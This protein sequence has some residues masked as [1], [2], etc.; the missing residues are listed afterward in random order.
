M[1]TKICFVC[2]EQITP[3]KPGVKS[4]G[5]RYHTNTQ[6]PD[7]FGECHG[8]TMNCM[9]WTQFHREIERRTQEALAADDAATAPAAP[10]TT[11]LT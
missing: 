9:R 7:P 1:S 8:L 5:K 11:D 2:G 10:D 6:I 4:R 3:A